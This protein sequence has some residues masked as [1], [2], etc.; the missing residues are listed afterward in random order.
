VRLTTVFLPLYIILILLWPSV[1]TDSRFLLPVFPLLAIY[2]LAGARGVSARLW[3][4]TGSAAMVTVAVLFLGL[5][6]AS[7]HE[8]VPVRRACQIAWHRGE[9]CVGEEYAE[10]LRAAAWAR[11][12][13]PDS[14]IVASRQ[15][16]LFYL[17]SRRQGS[18]YAFSSV[19]EVVIRD[20]EAMGATYVLVGRTSV[21]TPLY[22]APAVNANPD[23][24][25]LVF[26]AGSTVLFEFLY[27]EEVRSEPAGGAGLALAAGGATLPAIR[28]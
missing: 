22:L 28:Q 14:A 17:G 24:F 12:H 9:A 19:P 15:P 16:A 8:R 25:R 2:S 23:R 18:V 7:T 4:G 27:G 1:W 5:G 6:A 13:T 26:Q 11:D 10:L 3:P 20:L 21:T